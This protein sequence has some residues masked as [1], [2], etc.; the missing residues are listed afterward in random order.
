MKFVALLQVQV[1]WAVEGNLNVFDEGFAEQMEAMFERDL[2]V[3]SRVT[4][5]EWKRRP[6]SEK[7]LERIYGLFRRQY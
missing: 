7:I 4:L 3:S 5:E 1:A 6:L 2:V